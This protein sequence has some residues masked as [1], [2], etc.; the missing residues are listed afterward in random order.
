MAK[1]ARFEEG[2]IKVFSCFFKTLKNFKIDKNKRKK[3]YLLRIKINFS[4]RLFFY[5]KVS[6]IF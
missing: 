2:M 1:Y 5:I 6:A 4:N 3:T